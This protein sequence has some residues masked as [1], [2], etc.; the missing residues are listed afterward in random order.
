[1]AIEFNADE[2]L[3]IAEEIE[4]NGAAFYRKAAEMFADREKRDLLLQLA[5]M[6]DHHLQIFREMRAHITAKEARPFTYDPEGEALLYLKAFADGNIFDTSIKPAD[7]LTGDQTL[8][9]VLAMA[10]DIEKDSV[11]FYSGLRLL[12]PP[13]LGRDKVEDV[14]AEELKHI[15]TLNRELVSAS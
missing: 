4:T 3:G 5:A 8:P 14:I 10:I 15:T 12:V 7:R 9:D 6:E 2:I 13:E 1:M 11:V